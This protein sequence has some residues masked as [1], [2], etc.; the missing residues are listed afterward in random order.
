MCQNSFE[1]LWFYRMMFSRIF[2]IDFY[3]HAKKEFLFYFILLLLLVTR[4]M[5]FSRRF[6]FGYIYI[7]T[8][9]VKKKNNKIKFFAIDSVFEEVSAKDD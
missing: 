6:S 2:P 8:V 3:K 5:S 7:C 4:Q 9:Y 1:G